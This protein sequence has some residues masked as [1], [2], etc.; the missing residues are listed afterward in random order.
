M[1]ARKELASTSAG[2][3]EVS[4]RSRENCL[5]S[6]NVL[7]RKMCGSTP[8]GVQ[9][10]VI[11]SGAGH[12]NSCIVNALPLPLTF[13]IQT[14]VPCTRSYFLFP[15]AKAATYLSVHSTF[16][17]SIVPSPISCNCRFPSASPLFRTQEKFLLEGVRAQWQRWG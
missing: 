13:S 5:L 16:T 8:S 9:C 4:S 3:S 17:H 2:S 7:C 10:H 1:A 11:A 6:E 14:H 15:F 12:L